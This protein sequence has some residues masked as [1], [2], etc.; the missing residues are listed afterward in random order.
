MK[1]VLITAC[2]NARTTLWKP[3]IEKFGAENI[4]I[5]TN[6]PEL[7]EM[8]NMR[9]IKQSNILSTENYFYEKSLKEITRQ[10]QNISIRI[11]HDKNT[12]AMIMEEF[13]VFCHQA[14]RLTIGAASTQ[15]LHS[16][17]TQTVDYWIAQIKTKI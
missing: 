11:K 8:L 16:I 13:G 6:T 15:E 2:N 12:L 7:R 5:C 14:C 3:I 17:Y 10:P 1:K 4:Y 9:G